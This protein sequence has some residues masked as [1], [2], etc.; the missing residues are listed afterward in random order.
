MQTIQSRPQ[1]QDAVT[2]TTETKH[3]ETVDVELVDVGESGFS[4]RLQRTTFT[5]AAETMGEDTTLTFE[6]DTDTAEFSA[7]F[8]DA[9]YTDLLPDAWTVVE[10]ALATEPVAPATV[11]PGLPAPQEDIEPVSLA[12]PEPVDVAPDLT[13]LSPPAAVEDV[14]GVPAM[15]YETFEPEL[16]VVEYRQDASLAGR[17][18]R[19]YHLRQEPLR[20]ANEI[21]PTAAYPA[22]DTAVG[23]EAVAEET[24][25]PTTYAAEQ[26]SAEEV[27]EHMFAAT[28]LEG[29]VELVADYGTIGDVDDDLDEAYWVDIDGMD[30]DRTE[31]FINGELADDAINAYQLGPGD[32]LTFVEDDMFSTADGEDAYCGDDSDDLYLADIVAEL[33]GEQVQSYTV[34]MEDV[35][36]VAEPAAAYPAPAA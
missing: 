4:V 29:T 15:P 18:E 32:T 22:G 19:G 2:E 35:E 26:R 3:D 11:S 6:E 34:S 9:H 20:P 33:D 12:S 10:E 14:D 27:V 5:A 17:D 30:M 16:T 25:L 1:P 24:T 23:E 31:F 13:V 21:A 8:V 28:E 36:G 7:A